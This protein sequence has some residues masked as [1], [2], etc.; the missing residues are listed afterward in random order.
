VQTDLLEALADQF[1]RH[2]EHEGAVLSEYRELAEGL[3]DSTAG[4]LVNQILT[5]EE[6][7]HL[8]LRTMAT[9]LRGER[10]GA[11]AMRVPA[12]ANRVE[13]LRRTRVLATHERETIEACRDLQSLLAGEHAALL[14]ALLEVLV[15]DSQK[16]EKLL[17]AVERLLTSA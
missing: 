5:D 12:A 10:A 8:L 2:A 4:V 3:G 14:G 7:H 9:W 13:L 15:L 1:E 16:H 17:R 6:V 11:D